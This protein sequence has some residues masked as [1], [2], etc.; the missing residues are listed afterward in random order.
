MA[1]SDYAGREVAANR[2][3]SAMNPQ[4]IEFAFRFCP[5]C[6]RENA[7]LGSVP[8]RCDACGFCHFFGPVAAVGGLVIRDHDQLLL[9]RRARDPGKG[10]W[11]LPG[12]FVDRNETIEQA[13]AREVLEETGLTVTRFQYLI[14]HPNAYNYRNVVAPVIDLFYL[15]EVKADERVDL[16]AEEL[17]HFEWARPGSRHLDQM[18]FPSNRLA[19]E[20]WLAQQSG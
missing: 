7:Q 3:E 6:G 10:K 12:G 2:R 5:A 16:D 9:V 19:I 20:H 1:N 8:F 17:E 14:S 15:C 11:G 13:L 4:P 18:A